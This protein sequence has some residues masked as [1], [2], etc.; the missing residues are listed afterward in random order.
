[1]LAGPTSVSGR[2]IAVPWGVSAM[3]VLGHCEEP[4]LFRTWG[5][6]VLIT[7]ILG[8]MWTLLI[9][10]STLLGR[11][12]YLPLPVEENRIE[13]VRGSAWSVAELEFIPG[14]RLWKLK[15]PTGLDCPLPSCLPPCQPASCCRV[16][17]LTSKEN[18]GKI[19]PP[20]S[21]LV[22][23]SRDCAGDSSRKFII[24]I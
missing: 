21:H 1:M 14:P 22:S 5:L 10:A 3:V 19:L 11:C 20:V 18:L 4:V 16:F 13:Y 24:H 9:F 23:G 17:C 12:G 6:N 15:S 2:G 8:C 7:I